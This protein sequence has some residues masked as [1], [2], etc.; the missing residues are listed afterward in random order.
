MHTTQGAYTSA[1]LFP[2]EH[3]R[4]G[5]VYLKEPCCQTINFNTSHPIRLYVQL[6]H[7]MHFFYVGSRVSLKD[8]S[9]HVQFYGVNALKQELIYIC[10]PHKTLE[11]LSW[12]LY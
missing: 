3:F 10:I 11:Q 7:F 1:L 8:I 9:R 6:M 4:P 12:G 5:Q 2:K